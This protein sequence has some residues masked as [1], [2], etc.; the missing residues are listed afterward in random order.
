MPLRVE[1]RRRRSRVE[2]PRHRSRGDLVHRLVED[3]HDA[4][5][6]HERAL[7]PPVDRRR[8]GRRRGREAL[9]RGVDERRRGRGV[10]DR[11]REHVR[12]LGLG[13]RSL[14]DVVG[15]RAVADGRDR[16]RSLRRPA[17]GRA[18]DGRA[19]P[20]RAVVRERAGADGSAHAAGTA[21][22]ST[23]RRKRSCRTR[24]CSASC[25]R[26]CSNW[27]WRA[28][29]S[30][31]TRTACRCRCRRAR[32]CGARP[33]RTGSTRTS[34]CCTRATCWCRS[35]SSGSCTAARASTSAGT[36]RSC[37]PT[38]SPR[39]RRSRSAPATSRSS[40]TG[41][42]RATGR[43]ACLLADRLEPA[44]ARRGRRGLRAQGVH[45]RH[46]LGHRLVRPVGR[47]A[48]QEARDAHRRGARSRPT[49]RRPRT[50]APPTRCSHARATCS[51]P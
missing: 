18:R 40:P 31:W 23:R 39:P 7:G 42:C 26:T 36:S 13:R 51:R 9:R 38:C 50:T 12:V 34:S 6:A 25:R 44:H 16:T 8:A 1:R 32:S 24:T 29:A 3:V 11:H 5:D 48:R 4:R 20:H 37:S 19:L 2:P 10:R 21:T 47:R 17:R 28:T 30:R 22:S 41:T 15:D 49:P 46:D 45:A 14:L 43:R 27:R 33:A 35:T